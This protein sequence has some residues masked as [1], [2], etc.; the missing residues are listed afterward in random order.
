MGMSS[1]INIFERVAEIQGWKTDGGPLFAGEPRSAVSEEAAVIEWQTI[2]KTLNEPFAELTQ[3]MAEGIEHV[4]VIFEFQKPVKKHKGK[5]LGESLS[6][7]EAKGDSIR[8]GDP[9]FASHFDGRTKKFYEKRKVTLREWCEQKNI[10]LPPGSF[11]T[12]FQWSWSD[13]TN[14]PRQERDQRQLFIILF[15]SLSVLRRRAR[16]IAIVF[17]P[18][19]VPTN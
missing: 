6:D 5:N 18:Q 13:G 12:S 10:K 8:P 11:E 16:I 3:A 1:I 4:M 15:V 9:D 17:M 14:G 19:R 2:M 7:V